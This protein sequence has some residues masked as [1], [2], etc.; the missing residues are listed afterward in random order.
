[1]RGRNLSLA[2]M[3]G[4]EVRFVT[5]WVT[6]RRA[7]GAVSPS[8]RALARLMVDQADPDPSGFTLELGPGTGVFTQALIETG[9]P[10]DHIIAVEHNSEFC[11]LLAKRFPTLNIVQG[12]AFD[13]EKTLAGYAEIQFSAALSGLP[14][15]SFPRPLRLKFIEGVLDRLLP[16]RGLVQ[17]SYGPQGPLPAIPGRIA[18]AKSKWVLMNLPPARVWTYTRP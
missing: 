6:N 2:E 7:I 8:S 5:S 10:A 13:L 4:D 9:I 15:L 11:R 16:G 1:M 3:I 18:A 17:F 14:L 12:D